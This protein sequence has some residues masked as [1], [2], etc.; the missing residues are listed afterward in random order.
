MV[1]RHVEDRARR[2]LS[3]AFPDSKE[4]QMKVEETSNAR[5]TRVTLLNKAGVPFP[6]YYFLVD[7]DDEVVVFGD[8]HLPQNRMV[9]LADVGA[10]I[11]VG[12]Q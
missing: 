4:Y 12:E 7:M 10:A 1:T 3:S 6:L 5:F 8:P 2:L 11:K 9:E